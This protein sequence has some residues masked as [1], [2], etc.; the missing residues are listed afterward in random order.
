MAK[1]RFF[2]LEITQAKAVVKVLP[3]PFCGSFQKNT[4]P[5]VQGDG[6]ESCYIQCGDVSCRAQGPA[7]VSQEDAV[8]CWN[9]RNPTKKRK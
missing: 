1:E 8:I 2:N 7:C 4:N 6:S 3:C 5:F 9:D